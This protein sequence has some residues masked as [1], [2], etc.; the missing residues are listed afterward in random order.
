MIVFDLVVNNFDVF[1]A[2]IDTLKGFPANVAR[3][4]VSM[5]CSVVEIE[6]L[7]SVKYSRAQLAVATALD[8]FEEL[9]ELIFLGSRRRFADFDDSRAVFLMFR[10]FEVVSETSSADV[11]QN[12][13]RN[14]VIQIQMSVQCILHCVRE[15]RTRGV[16]ARELF[17][18]L[19]GVTLDVF[20]QTFLTF[21]LEPT[22]VA[23]K[24]LARVPVF[25]MNLAFM[26]LEMRL[27]RE[28][29]GTHRAQER[30]AKE[31]SLH[32]VLGGKYRGAF[33]VT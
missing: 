21:R 14:V 24:H 31:V 10:H 17:I 1:V 18:A 26:S 22:N 3:F 9:A 7:F 28:A 12:R 6:V 19:D 25:E 8:G 29:F 27:L 16:R 5:E 11:A 13:S 2:M 32:A 4:S 23:V 20:S 30:I 33:L 15:I